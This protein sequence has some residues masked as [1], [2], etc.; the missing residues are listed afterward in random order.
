M[1]GVHFFQK[2]YT[3]SLRLTKIVGHFFRKSSKEVSYDQ[4]FP[5]ANPVDFDK[6]GQWFCNWR[7]KSNVNGTTSIAS[8]HL[9]GCTTTISLKKKNEM[10]VNY[11]KLFS[12]NI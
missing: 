1:L 11:L 7:L 2:M 8:P 10:N 9:K 5:L 3:F 4:V 6:T 12:K